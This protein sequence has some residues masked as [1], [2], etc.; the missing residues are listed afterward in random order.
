MSQRLATFNR[1]YTTRSC[2][3]QCY[4][5]NGV[6]TTENVLAVS[7]DGHE[8]APDFTFS[9]KNHAKLHNYKQQII[10]H[11]IQSVEDIE[12]WLRFTSEHISIPELNT[13]NTSQDGSE[14]GLTE[15]L[16]EISDKELS[17]DIELT[18]RKL[19]IGYDAILAKLQ[20]EKILPANVKDAFILPNLHLDDLI[21]AQKLV[22]SYSQSCCSNTDI[23]FENLSDKSQENA[24][25]DVKDIVKIA[26]PKNEIKSK[27]QNQELKINKT[28]MMN[29][30]KTDSFD[31]SITMSIQDLSIENDSS[32]GSSHSNHCTNLENEFI[33]CESENLNLPVVA[34]KKSTEYNTRKKSTNSPNVKSKFQPSIVKRKR[35]VNNQESTL[36][37][38]STEYLLKEEPLN[39]TDKTFAKKSPKSSTYD[40][41]GSE[42]DDLYKGRPP[43]FVTDQELIISKALEEVGITEDSLEFFYNSMNMKTWKCHLGNCGRTFAK[44]C[45]LKVH[46]MAHMNI[47]PFKCDYSSCSWAFY[48]E[49]KL[50]RHKKTHLNKKDYVCPVPGCQ[51]RFTT[52][53]N[54]ASHEKLHTRP[55]KIACQVTECTAKF[56]T[57][58]ALENHM[59]CHNQ[60]LAPYACNYDGCNKRFY[61]SNA[62]M[63]HQRCH[64]YT[65]E[66]LTCSWPGCGKIFDQP[67][68]KRAHMRSHTGQKPYVCTFEDCDWAFST[69]S[70]LKRHQK[71]HTNDRKF[72]CDEDGC[73]KTFMRSQHLKEHKLT[74]TKKISFR[75]YHCDTSFAAKS[76]LYVHMK[77]HMS[78][79][80]ILKLQE[81]DDIDKYT[82]L[83]SIPKE[84]SSNESSGSESIL[85]EE[86]EN[87]SVAPECTEMPTAN[88]VL[89]KMYKCPNESC[90][91]WY[92]HRSSLR[93]HMNK[94]T[95][96]LSEIQNDN[97]VNLE[98]NAISNLSIPKPN[99]GAARTAFTCEYVLSLKPDRQ[100]TGLNEV[101]TVE[102]SE[103][104]LF[105]K[106]VPSIYFQDDVTLSTY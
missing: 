104:L 19:N 30:L 16:S 81:K 95:L 3:Q 13:K 85:R 63:T 9:H 24:S 105:N 27:K 37:T 56:Q 72:I 73:T 31:S 77:I 33:S 57:K 39:E 51:R 49:F 1:V 94:H 92:S 54:L 35:K 4:Y 28:E 22:S 46:L 91:K 12:K 71:K 75:C 38:V 98:E 48:S 65:E 59:K 42:S 25:N 50:K 70:K 103:G 55:N 99:E 78:T 74:H 36:N 100:I 41:S 58:R 67:C 83:L 6:T 26:E 88:V 47:K 23:N 102:L 14:R 18:A 34:Q 60:I 79:D 61:S 53:Y 101:G 62:L 40:S 87:I 90:S 69:S 89:H 86:T 45:Y 80:Y 93:V 7:A 64:N 97:E 17:T 84:K 43:P 76:S 32:D 20:N 8:V 96:P 21:I 52:I 106:S 68:R 5:G 29:H 66:D 82:R 15:Q 11:T 10:G 44:L 2:R